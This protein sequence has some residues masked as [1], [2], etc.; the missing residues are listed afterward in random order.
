M[1]S[2]SLVSSEVTM[3]NSNATSK[4]PQQHSDDGVKTLSK[5]LPIAIAIVLANGLVFALFYRCRLLRTSSNYVLLS[6]AVCDFSTGAIAIPYLI[7]CSFAILPK[8]LNYGIYYLHTS[9]AV[10]GAYHILVITALKYLATVRP[11]KHH[12][13]TKGLV[14]KILFGIWIMSTVFAVIPLVWQGAE[15]SQRRRWR[16]IYNSV[17]LVTV[18]LLPY[19]YIIHVF[20]AMFRTISNRQRSSLVQKKNIPQNKKK[21]QSDRKCILVF[22]AMAIIFTC[23]WLPYFTIKLLLGMGIQ[24]LLNVMEAVV[25]IR[26]ITSFAKP[27]LYTGVFQTRLL[28]FLAK[29]VAKQG[30]CQPFCSKKIKILS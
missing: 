21:S 27:L 17:C 25:I 28:V 26:Y 3:I 18:F 5:L 4:F 8:E 22:A 30:K 13:V 15:V 20:L 10:S 19:I 23:S 11:L 24:V 29:S 1:F 9:L 7:V 6:L 12:V 16:S 2:S 14:L